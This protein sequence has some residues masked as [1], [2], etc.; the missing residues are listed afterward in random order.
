VNISNDEYEQI[1]VRMNSLTERQNKWVSNKCNWEHITR[2]AVGIYYTIPED[3]NLCEHG[4][5]DCL[6]CTIGAD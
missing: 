4:M 5:E 2:M 3:G 1:K 6:S